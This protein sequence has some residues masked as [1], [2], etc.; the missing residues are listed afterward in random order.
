MGIVSELNHAKN[1]KSVGLDLNPTQVIFF[2]NPKLGTPLMQ[3]NPLD[4]FRFTTKN[5]VSQ[6]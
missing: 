4:W 6:K 3:T 5:V 1:A 2:G